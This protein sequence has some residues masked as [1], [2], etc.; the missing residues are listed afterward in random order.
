MFTLSDYAN[1]GYIDTYENPEFEFQ[2]NSSPTI[3]YIKNG[4]DFY[5]YDGDPKELNEIIFFIEKGHLSQL[6]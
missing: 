4:E 5:K 2:I 1:V 6:P 3:I